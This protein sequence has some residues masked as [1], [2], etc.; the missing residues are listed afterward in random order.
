MVVRLG[1]PW[2]SYGLFAFYL[3]AMTGFV[4][5]GITFIASGKP[6]NTQLR[7]GTLLALVPATVMIGILLLV[8]LVVTIRNPRTIGRVVVLTS[9]ELRMPR[10]KKGRIPLG[11]VAGVGLAMQ[12]GSWGLMVWRSDGSHEY[13]GG[14]Q[15]KEQAA[16]PERTRV[17]V[18][19]TEVY[20]YVLARQGLDG[21]LA[22]RALQRDPLVS[23]YSAFT[24]FWDPAT[25]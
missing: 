13:A 19:A 21:P 11:D 17:G 23:R 20:R 2:L 4:V 9:T 7:F 6:T 18:A 8:V 1:N 10:R 15:T 22:Q 16:A 25:Q 3:A 14:L 5:M 12:R 24:R